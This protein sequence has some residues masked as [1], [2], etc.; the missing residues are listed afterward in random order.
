MKKTDYL[1]IN[2]KI[3][4]FF[5]LCF[6]YFIY[7]ICKL[8]YGRKKNWLICERGNDAQDN[9]YFFYKYLVEKH[10]E[11]KPVFVI[12]KNSKDYKNIKNL[13]KSVG[14]CSLKH[15]FMVIGYPVKISSHLFGYAPWIQLNLFYR[16]HKTHDKHIF[17]QHGIIKNTH[18]GLY[19][20]VCKSLNL[21]VC[22]AKA[23]YIFIRDTF[24]YH[25]G[26]PQYTGLARYDNLI[27]F[28]TKNQILFMPTWRAK[29]SGLSDEDFEKSD[30]FLYWSSLCN[31]K[32]LIQ[33][34]KERG[35]IIKFYMH[36]SFQK[37]SHLLKENEVL[38]VIS[39]GQEKVQTLLKESKLLITDF[40]SVFF[41]FAFMQ[42][43]L[44]YYQ[45]DEDTFYDEHYAKGYFDYWKDGFGPV[46][47]NPKDIL[48]RILLYIDKDFKNE[49]RYL[50]RMISFFE[51]RDC[52]NCERIFNSIKKMC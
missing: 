21:F 35:L 22:G 5:F 8:I 51:F 14:F 10:P 31:S 7:P 41:D 38:K 11:I 24:H 43:P 13:G 3:K 34:C 50:G 29:L 52:Y 42:K 2:S 36:H 16:R 48:E 6:Y 32:A 1:K 18:E 46:C 26:I 33:K 12:T 23:E 37:Y 40:S 15:L 45:F 47:L 25:K 30:F 17:L 19:G 49:A 4:Y 44:I 39:F 27:N 20:D 28:E 9:G